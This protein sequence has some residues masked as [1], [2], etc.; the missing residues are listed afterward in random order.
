MFIHNH[1]DV[2]PGGD[3]K[4][5]FRADHRLEID[6][7][8]SFDH[9]SL[10]MLYA[11]FKHRPTREVSEDGHTT[12]LPPFECAWLL[13][14]EAG[15]KAARRLGSVCSDHENDALDLSCFT[16]RTVVLG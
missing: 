12:F 6:P 11:V 1:Q 10:L 14:E 2:L 13:I 3:C 7:T 9:L 16:M 4:W 15:D 8:I 5:D